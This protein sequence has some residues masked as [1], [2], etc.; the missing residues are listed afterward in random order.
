M[1]RVTV[2]NENIHEK[3]MPEVRAIYPE[4][5]HGALAAY[6]N[7]LEGVEART[8]TLDQP[9]CG[10]PDEV[11]NS[12]DVLLWWG[13]CGHHLVPD[14]LARKVANRVL[15][16][17]GLIVLHSGHYSKPFGLLMG[18]TCSLRWREGD[19]ERVWCVNPGHP[20]AQGVPAW[21]ELEQEEMYGEHF[22]VPQPTSWSMRAGSG[23][24]SCSV[25]AA[26]GTAAR[27]RCFISSRGMKL[28]RPTTIP[29]YSGSSAMPSAGRR[30]TLEKH[31]G[32]LPYGGKHGRAVCRRARR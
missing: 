22:D 25:P 14:E 1:L 20:I 8:A 7:T 15:S 23:A 21:F 29:T 13:H 28:T 16:G 10:L 17:M 30:H 11:L 6:L 26:A 27:A 19:F 24:A 12:T 32:M 9:D 3:E 4:G 18:T 31:A 2:W 5:I